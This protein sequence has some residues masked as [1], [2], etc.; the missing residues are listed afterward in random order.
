MIVSWRSYFL[1]NLPED[2]LGRAYQNP[3]L[4]VNYLYD[5]VKID[6]EDNYYNTPLTPIGVNE[7]GVSDNNSRAICFVA[8]CRTLGIPARL[9]PGRNIPQYFDA[10]AWNDVFFADQI[11]PGSKKGFIKF[12]SKDTNPVPEYYIHFTLARFENGR[13]NTLEYDYNKK[14][15]DFKDEIPL[16]PGDYMLVTGNRLNNGKI[17]AGISFFRLLENERKT[18]EVKLRKD[19][20]ENK[21]FGKINLNNLMTLISDKN[22][23]LCRGN[24]KGFVAIWI[25]PEKEPTKHIFNDLPLLKSELDSWGGEF[26]FL[27][28]SQQDNITFDPRILKGLPE[29]THFGTDNNFEILKNSVTFNDTEEKKFP[30]VVMS[31]KNGNIIFTSSGYRIGIGEQILKSVR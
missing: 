7:L 13:Y 1:K 10:N 6:N 8:I 12:A 2:I 25:E 19:F 3:A 5:N 21:I 17:L 31:D 18:I 15:T 9:E 26:L 29:L 16:P 4:I 23:K 28:G 30:L 14:I 20:S 27:S 11:Q 24:E 22:S